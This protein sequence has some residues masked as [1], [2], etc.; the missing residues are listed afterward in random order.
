MAPAEQRKTLFSKS[1]TFDSIP[2]TSSHSR[3]S[4]EDLE[5]DD[6]RAEEVGPGAPLGIEA[7][8]VD[9]IDGKSDRFHSATLRAMRDTHLVCD[10]LS[11]C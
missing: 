9:L 10:P 4:S 2:R 6:G 3:S 7:I 1:T 8:G 11:P 5:D